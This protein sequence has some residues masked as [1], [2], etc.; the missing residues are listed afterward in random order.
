MDWQQALA[1]RLVADAA[2]SAIA[3]DHWDWDEREQTTPLPC[4]VLVLVSDPRPQNLK[5]FQ[6]RRES[7]VQVN[8]LAADRGTVAQLREAAIAALVPG[9]EFDG[10]SFSR[11][12]IENGSGQAE[13]TEGGSLFRARFDVVVFHD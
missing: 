11:A 2:C 3:A 12:M 1:R 6:G 7:R 10:V 9:G 5:G 13:K 4:G 8:C